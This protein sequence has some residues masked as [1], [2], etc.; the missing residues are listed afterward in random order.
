M[1]TYRQQS[2]GSRRKGGIKIIA[3]VIGFQY[4]SHKE[5]R[6]VYLYV[7]GH[8]PEGQLDHRDTDK[9]NNHPDNLRIATSQQNIHNR[10]K[11]KGS[12]KYQGVH[13]AEK[14]Q[15]W[16]VRIRNP[17]TSRKEYLG[18]FVRQDEDIAGATYAAKAREY[19]G[20]FY[21]PIENS[22]SNGINDLQQQF[23]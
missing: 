5:H 16:H 15:R 6:L 12:S 11:L 3:R 17:I 1:D 14:D 21:R 10:K 18:S 4:R 23:I 13:W 9:L 2:H 19:H 20:E 8:W 7:H 22:I